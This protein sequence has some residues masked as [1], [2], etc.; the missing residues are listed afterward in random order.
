MMA[1]LAKAPSASLPLPS[2]ASPR[3]QWPTMRRSLSSASAAAISPGP[4]TPGSSCRCSLSSSFRVFICPSTSSSVDVNALTVSAS[5]LRIRGAS[6]IKNCALSVSSGSG[7][8]RLGREAD[9]LAEPVLLS[10]AVSSLCCIDV[11]LVTSA[12]EVFNSCTR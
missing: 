3:R 4:P 9:A 1:T 11:R 5:N 10:A 6:F 12:V 7:A 8:R 2:R